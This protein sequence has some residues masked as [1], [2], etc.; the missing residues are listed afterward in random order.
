MIIPDPYKRY[1]TG[2]DGEETQVLLHGEHIRV[3]TDY[4]TGHPTHLTIE[5]AKELRD[6]LDEA[7]WLHELAF[8]GEYMKSEAEIK[9]ALG[10]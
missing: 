4:W 1:V 2:V 6:A 3:C 7:I 9:A 5:Q 10:Q 8:D